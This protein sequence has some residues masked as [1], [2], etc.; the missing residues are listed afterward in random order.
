MKLPLK[1]TALLSVL[2]SLMAIAFGLW[3]WQGAQ[4]GAAAQKH[5]S[6]L[7]QQL[8]PVWAADPANAGESLPPVGRSLFDFLVIDGESAKV[9]FPFEALTK[10][11]DSRLG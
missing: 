3:R 7:P 9:P 8:A 2:G 4:N 10:K 1:S 11:I 5:V 6:S